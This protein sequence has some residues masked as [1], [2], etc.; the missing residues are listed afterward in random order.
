MYI[1]HQTRRSRYSCIAWFVQLIHIVCCHQSCVRAFVLSVCLCLSVSGVHIVSVTHS[2]LAFIFS[3]SVLEPCKAD[4]QLPQQLVY[5]WLHKWGGQQQHYPGWLLPPAAVLWHWLSDRDDWRGK[6]QNQK[7]CICP[8]NGQF[9]LVL[10]KMIC[11]KMPSKTFQAQGHFFCS[12]QFGSQDL[13][14]LV[15]KERLT[16]QY[17]ESKKR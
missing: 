10:F 4:R 13:S 14:P 11:D 2:P 17:E 8:N 6:V 9:S 15:D 5:W 7:T 3:P 1:C 12:I 16:W